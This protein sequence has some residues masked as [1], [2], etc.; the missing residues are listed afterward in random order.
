MR[1]VSLLSVIRFSLCFDCTACA[2]VC[3]FCTSEPPVIVD[4]GTRQRACTS[5]AV[6]HASGA[7]DADV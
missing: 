4:L 1:A 3:P 7:R 6:R 2:S 5:R